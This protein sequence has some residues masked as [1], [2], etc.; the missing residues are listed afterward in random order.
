[1]PEHKPRKPTCNANDIGQ[2]LKR[3]D[4]SPFLE[5]L[6]FFL[7]CIPDAERIQDFANKKP[8]L[9]VK[10]MTDLAK[11]GGFTEKQEVQHTVRLDQLSDSQ[12]EDRM[13]ELAAKHGLPVPDRKPGRLI[14]LQPVPEPEV[15]S[16]DSPYRK[17]MR[18]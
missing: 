12:L 10:A 17:A 11:I 6:A 3:Y 15:L 9:W 2:L 8:D 4:R 7:E 14:D 18:E 13:R 16:P 5:L 1:M